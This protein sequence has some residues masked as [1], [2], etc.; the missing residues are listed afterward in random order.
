[1]LLIVQLLSCVQLFATPWTAAHQAS[2]PFTISR[3]LLKLTSIKLVM[4]SNYLILCHPLLLPWIFPSIRVFSNNSVLR[5]RW[6]KFW[7]FSFSI[8][9]SSE[10]SDT[11]N[12]SLLLA[13][14]LLWNSGPSLVASKNGWAGSMKGQTSVQI[15]VLLGNIW[16]QTFQSLFWSLIPVGREVLP[17]L[18]ISALWKMRHNWDTEERTGKRKAQS[19]VP[20]SWLLVSNAAKGKRSGTKTKLQWNLCVP[21]EETVSL[22]L[23]S[24]FFKDASIHTTL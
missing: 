17:K 24:V 19:S 16:Q 4:P 7:S 13:R 21:G 15:S 12:Y 8:S 5:I 20:C 6:P 14:I 2:L 3:S 22:R 23:V 1:M 10:Y 18:E 11:Q 9:P